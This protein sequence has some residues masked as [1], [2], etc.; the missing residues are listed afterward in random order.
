MRFFA[1]LVFCLP[2]SSLWAQTYVIS[3]VAGGSPAPASAAATSLALGQ[4]GR[5]A[6]DPAGHVYFTA[7]NSVYRLDSSGNAIRIAGN[8]RPGFSGDNG[9]ALNAQ[10]NA[11]QGLAIDTAGD[12]YVADTTASLRVRSRRRHYR[13]GHSL[14]ILL[15]RITAVVSAVC[16]TTKRNNFR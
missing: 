13:S 2:L 11:P 14:P 3:T 1:G 9:P 15:S 4:P 6:L 10:L 7:L 8:G 16:P 5:V 12:V